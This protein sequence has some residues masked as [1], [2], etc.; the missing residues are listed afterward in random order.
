MRNKTHCATG[1]AVMEA[2]GV[3]GQHLAPPLLAFRVVTAGGAAGLPDLD[4]QHSYSAAA[5][6]WITEGLS[7]IVAKIS[8]GH[9]EGTHTAIGDLVAAGL[10]AVAVAY[11][12]DW[13]GMACLAFYL[14]VMYGTALEAAGLFRRR[15]HIV[16]ELVACAAAAAVTVTGYDTG[17]IA[18]AVLLGTIVHCAGDSLTEHGVAWLEPVSRHRFHLLPK[19]LQIKTAHFAERVIIYPATILTLI[20]VALW[21]AG[22]LQPLQHGIY[23]YYLTHY[24]HNPPTAH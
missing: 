14:A 13:E 12:S 7:W 3:F 2:A 16:R 20:I 8:G 23:H 15:K 9:R 11:R 10:A 18:W 4:T 19:F 1:A 6:G 22:L 24:Q 17:G 5:L 21:D